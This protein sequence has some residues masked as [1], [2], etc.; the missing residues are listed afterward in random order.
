MTVRL[1]HL[2]DIHFGGENVAA[3]AA[4]AEHLNAGAFDL[5]VVSGDLTR[6]AE[7]PE[8]E[9]AA[10]W[11]Q[12]IRA[13]L[14]VTPGNHDAPYLAWAER[15]GGLPALIARSE[16]NLAAVRRILANLLDNALKFAG[17]AR[18]TLTVAGDT[19][20]A[21]VEDDGPG[22]PE[23][24]REAVFEP[25]R[26]L[27]PSRNRDTGGVGLGLAIARN[28]ARGHGGDI[29]LETASPAGARFVLS[30]PLR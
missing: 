16:A 23:A 30:L 24:M 29:T 13:P 18:V 7:T 14:L 25:F 19:V 2:S 3:V 9:A 11:L 27:E 4:A 1:A 26:R 17:H 12:G 10:S 15:I 6:Y 8:F 22:V 28:L 5:V 21:I 20:L